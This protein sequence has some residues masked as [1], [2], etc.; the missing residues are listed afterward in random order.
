[1]EAKT[2]EEEYIANC[3]TEIKEIKEKMKENEK[4]LKETEKQLPSHDEKKEIE[5][6][7]VEEFSIKKLSEILSEGELNHV[8]K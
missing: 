5:T 4:A 1:L 7:V 3:E 2:P 8:R 6:K